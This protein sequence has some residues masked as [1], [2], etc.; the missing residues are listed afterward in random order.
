MVSQD[1][2]VVANDFSS[3]YSHDSVNV[4][5]QIDQIINTTEVAESPNVQPSQDD[6]I[7]L[8]N[9]L[10]DALQSNPLKRNVLTDAEKE[11]W[12]QSAFEQSEIFTNTDGL[13]FGRFLLCIHKIKIGTDEVKYRCLI[14]DDFGLTS[15]EKLNIS[16]GSP[17]K[18]TIGALSSEDQKSDIKKCIAVALKQKFANLS[19][20][21]LEKLQSL[22]PNSKLENY[23]DTH[24]AQLASGCTE[25]P[26]ITSNVL[27]ERLLSQG[28]LGRH[29]VKSTLL[30]VIYQSNE[31]TIELNN[32]LVFHLGEQL[33]QLFNPI[34]EY[35]PEQTEYGYKIPEGGSAT[36][37]DTPLIKAICN[38]LLE[39]QSNFTFTLVEFLQKFLIPLRVKVLNNDIDGLSTVKLNRLFPPTIDE[40]TR[41][42]CIYLDSLKSATPYG[43]FEVLSACNVTIPYFYK[44]YTR[45]EAATKNFSKDI[46]LFLRNFADY[47]PLEDVYSEMKLE[48][49][50]RGPQEKI[51]KLK[52]IIERLQKKKVWSAKNND[53]AQE[54]YT[55]II[56]VIDSFGHL[57]APM[58]SYSTRVFTPSGKILTEL[59]KGWPVELQYKW[60]KRRVVGVFD[61]I[62]LNEP[63]KRKLLV[64]F[65]DYVVFLNIL[66]YK[67]Y[68]VT[69]EHNNKPLISDI[70]MNSLINEQ[71][72][73]PKIPKLQVEYYSYIKDIHTSV[74]EGNIIRFDAIRDE[75]DEPFSVICKLT[76]KNKNANEVADLITKAKILEKDTAFHLFKYENTNMVLYFTA[77][78]LEAYSGERIKSK[79]ALFLNVEPSEDILIENGLHS[80]AFV[81]FINPHQTNTIELDLISRNSHQRYDTLT[82]EADDLVPTLLSLLSKEIPLCYSSVSSD[83][84][85]PLLAIN[86]IV[87]SK[88][89]GEAITDTSSSSRK[90]TPNISN[91]VNEETKKSYGTITTFRSDVSDLVNVPIENSKIPKTE[92]MDPPTKEKTEKKTEEKKKTPKNVTP[93]VRSPE[94]PK[95][96]KVSK[97]IVTKDEKSSQKKKGKG[98]FGAIKSV[99]SSGNKDYN[100][101]KKKISSP[102]LVKPKKQPKL[103]SDKVKNKPLP[104]SPIKNKKDPKP[105]QNIEK[106]ANEVVAS[107][108]RVEKADVG[109]NQR[110]SSV[111]HNIGFTKQATD[112]KDATDEN[113]KVD[114]DGQNGAQD[115]DVPVE[116]GSTIN[117]TSE[118]IEDVPKSNVNA[119]T[120]V[121]IPINLEQNDKLEQLEESLDAK[122]AQIDVGNDTEE[123]LA[124]P[125]GQQGQLFDD[126][127]FGDFIPDDN[128]KK[129]IIPTKDAT[130]GKV[131]VP[132]PVA[133]VIPESD[134]GKPF[135]GNDKEA[136][137]TNEVEQDETIGY[138]DVPSP[139]KK[140]APMFPEIAKLEQPKSQIKFQ[141]SP[142]FIELFRDMRTVLDGTDAKY[143]WK[144]LSSEVSLNEKYL[145]N[146]DPVGEQNAL[147]PINEQSQALPRPTSPTMKFQPLDNTSPTRNSPVKSEG[148]PFRALA[149]HKMSELSP[150]RTQ[151]NAIASVDIPVLTKEPSYFDSSNILSSPVQT[152]ANEVAYSPSRT[153]HTKPGAIF[154][155]ISTSPSKFANKIPDDSTKDVISRTNEQR[156]IVNKSSVGLGLSGTGNK[157][158]STFQGD[159]K[160]GVSDF[161]FASDINNETNERLVKLQVNSREDLVEEI[162]HTPLEDPSETF[163]EGMFEKFGSSSPSTLKLT[164]KQISPQQGEKLSPANNKNIPHD[165]TEE[166]DDGNILDDLEFSSFDMTFGTTN[167]S[168]NTQSPVAIEKKEQGNVMHGLRYSHIP[169]MEPPVMYRYSRDASVDNKNSS[170][171]ERR[172]VTSP[173]YTVANDDD[174]FWISPSK[175]DF[176]SI[177]NS[178]KK[179]ATN[180]RTLDSSV[181]PVVS[182]KTASPIH[183]KKKEHSTE[184]TLSHDMS[185]AFLGNIV[186]LNS[187]DEGNERSKMYAGDKPTRLHFN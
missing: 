98:F 117:S 129:N 157:M 63:S 32:R 74:T 82:V 66:D 65:S 56:D 128:H 70:L 116:T 119:D 52:L 131:Q 64:I 154:K 167:G 7:V 139:L 73:P 49:I 147:E 3:L 94:S 54:Y 162:Y 181:R 22:R 160:N 180:N 102:V 161:T 61:I 97:K 15:M 60:L 85:S 106:V 125:A 19:E 133:E 4:E 89:M 26:G 48:S 11:L 88:L 68:Y 103:K 166:E 100:N 178:A 41:I 43:S 141:K 140:K 122:V 130:S 1:V 104:A 10:L 18:D 175:L 80:A 27:G 165:T 170:N 6:Q 158:D 172:N 47:I 185:F 109:I 152:H 174:P 101:N 108:P 176:T 28:Y 21:Q 87:T 143:N 24:V 81:K 113:K 112:K 164:H 36:E 182:D 149:H 86:S 95:K 25:V 118:P 135:S 17:Y 134:K 76:L 145:V 14:F 169:K 153:S 84:A 57:D 96:T 121:D 148:S 42:N 78:E 151:K 58:S 50:I 39:V 127:L 12:T 163:S 72:L 155:V 37:D 38:E 79:F 51:L 45:H 23:N 77:H 46:K 35:S 136:L 142:S 123:R 120:P 107:E 90:P 126:D 186:E 137:S 146:N 179:S 91:D 16:E 177:A 59:A 110:I 9:N 159:D 92:K 33:E 187:A 168:S 69:D 75:K 2:E 13:F 34:T 138:N 114:S 184:S 111:I 53:K 83:D 5:K 144:S 105:K 132:T 40:V 150:D 31:S 8:F 93:R 156:K 124:N 62:N 67:K 171:I 20:P 99:F 183:E 55:N 44:A 173:N 71:P 30:D 115:V 29:A